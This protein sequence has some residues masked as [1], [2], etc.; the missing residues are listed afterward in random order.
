M[1]FD[2]PSIVA[3][4]GELSA[5]SS[6]NFRHSLTLKRNE[7]DFNRFTSE[8]IWP[9]QLEGPEFDIQEWFTFGHEQSLEVELGCP[10][11]RFLAIKSGSSKE[12]G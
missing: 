11:E 8:N 10:R 9:S 4:F 3:I 7:I 6:R 1:N 12:L 2:I 5:V